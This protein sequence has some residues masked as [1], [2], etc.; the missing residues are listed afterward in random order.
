M[1]KNPFHREPES[2]PHFRHPC[3]QCGHGL[4][5]APILNGG[6][7][8]KSCGEPLKSQA[9]NENIGQ[10]HDQGK[11]RYDLLPF[12]GLESTIRVLEFGANKYGKNNW[13]RVENPEVRYAAAAMR[14]LAAY[15]KGEPTDSESGLSHVAHAACCCLFLAELEQNTTSNPQSD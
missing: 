14:H 11:P 9:P 6:W 7:I 15:L 1:K 5:H 12:D 8:C 4:L 2:I 10:K 13:R 3:P